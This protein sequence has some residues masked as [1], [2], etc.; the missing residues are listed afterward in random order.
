MKIP[1]V[2]HTEEQKRL[3]LKTAGMSGNTH[4]FDH[5]KSFV[6]QVSNHDYDLYISLKS[7]AT[8]LKPIMVKHIL[9]YITNENSAITNI[10][11]N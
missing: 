10:R 9:N 5:I 11:K 3:M 4:M 7:A 1:G 6:I 8:N 2:E